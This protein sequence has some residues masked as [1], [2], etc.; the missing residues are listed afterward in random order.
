[1]FDS[2]ALNP[3]HCPLNPKLRMAVVWAFKW[4]RLLQPGPVLLEGSFGFHT[5]HL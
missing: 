2:Q 5:E 4:R 1:M 3:K